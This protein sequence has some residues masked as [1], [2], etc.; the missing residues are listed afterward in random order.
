M[1]NVLLYSKFSPNCEKLFSL[2][3]AI[4]DFLQY[5]RIVPICIDNQAVRNKILQEGKIMVNYVPTLLIMMGNGTIEKYEG[6]YVFEWVREKI[7]PEPQKYEMGDN[8]NG[9]G[10]GTRDQQEPPIMEKPPITRERNRAPDNR[11]LSGQ[12][13]RKTPIPKNENTPT[14]KPENPERPPK[15]NPG[16]TKITEIQE[17]EPEDDLFEDGD[18]ENTDDIN[19]MDDIL[20]DIE[21]REPPPVKSPN[22][23]INVQAAMAQAEA[24]RLKLEE[25][26]SSTRKRPPVLRR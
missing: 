5:F 23:K 15:R 24:H 26:I 7:K 16:S 25:Q 17:E 9:N 14:F 21:E 18:T 20:E 12:S 1:N 3:N 4:P 8:L 2:I 11:N 19:D 13:I 22:G 10:N 6:E